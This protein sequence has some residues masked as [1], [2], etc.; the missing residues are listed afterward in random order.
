MLLE[1]S[2]TSARVVRNPCPGAAGTGAQVTPKRV[3]ESRR[4]TH[5][6]VVPTIS[7]YFTNAWALGRTRPTVVTIYIYLQ[8]LLAALL[9]WLGVPVTSRAVVA[10]AFILSGVALVTMRRQM[11]GRHSAT[12][13]R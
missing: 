5:F 9:Q 12:V 10:S 3:P 2:G 4:N 11:D 1:C 13:R 6:V 8:P 7:A